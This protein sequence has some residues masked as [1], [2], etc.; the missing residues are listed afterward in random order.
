MPNPQPIVVKRGEAR[1]T[2]ILCGRG[3]GV[4]CHPGNIYYLKLIKKHQSIYQHGKG[5][6]QSLSQREKRKIV[7]HII[8]SID[9]LD[10]PGRFLKLVGRD[11]EHGFEEIYHVIKDDDTRMKK[12]SQALREK[13]KKANV[14]K[15]QQQQDEDQR[16]MEAIERSHQ[17]NG[18]FE[19][20]KPL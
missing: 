14:M 5:G 1:N 4:L 12:V 6:M 15:E 18:E 3:N 7:R 19:T 11:T 8:E 20:W 17:R 10:P 16:R 13:P 9:E 2:D